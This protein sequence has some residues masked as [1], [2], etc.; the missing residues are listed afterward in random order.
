[1]RINKDINIFYQNIDF[2]SILNKGDIIAG[3]ILDA[4][5]KNLLLFINELGVINAISENNLEAHIGKETTFIVQSLSEGILK[6][7]PNLEY[8]SKEANLEL[9]A[10]R[11]EYINNIFEEFKIE[12]TQVNKDFIRSLLEYR[13]KLEEKNISTGINLLNRIKNIIKLDE[14]DISLNYNDLESGHIDSKHINNEQM[15]N[16]K[17]NNKYIDYELEDSNLIESSINKPNYLS[18]DNNFIQL[19]HLLK[20]NE[21]QLL[22]KTLAFFIKYNIK[23]SLRNIISFLELNIDL[24]LFS[25]DYE[26]LKNIMDKEFTNH[27]K[28]IIISNEGSE[29]MVEEG[30]N[31]YLSTIDRILKGVKAEKNK[32][33]KELHSLFDKLESKL[34]LIRELNN[35]LAFIYLPIDVN[36]ELSSIITLIKKKRHK[37]DYQDE[38]NIFI[39]L[40]TVNLCKVEVFIKAIHS[41][42]IIEF[43][44]LNM[45]VIHYIK[46]REKHLKEV[47]GSVG[48]NIASVTYVEK[49]D[50]NILNIMATN[51]NP[52]YCLDVKV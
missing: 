40:R 46:S 20:S 31:I 26:I 25:K 8:V 12:K 17:L 2:K 34:E 44:N 18:E 9:P 38:I 3:K 52:L 51:S 37:Y 27:Y 6:I 11:E 21:P 14:E 16:E 50:L 33:N 30:Q 36:K 15:A 22:P 29:T 49:T 35:G 5:G 32:S 28:N 48:Y 41:D 10:K 19:K 4:K 42:L 24:E 47:L 1:M 7:K 23:P 13:V 43:S 45:E 39:S